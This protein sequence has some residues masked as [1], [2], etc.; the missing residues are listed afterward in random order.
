MREADDAEQSEMARSLAW[1]LKYATQTGE[2]IRSVVPS[3]EPLENASSQN[4][5]HRQ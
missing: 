2:K 1:A 5:M 4:S 3:C